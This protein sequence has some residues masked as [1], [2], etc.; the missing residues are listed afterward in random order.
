MT[1]IEF[2]KRLIV[3]EVSNERVKDEL[4]LLYD[5]TFHEAF[6]ILDRDSKGSLEVYDLISALQREFGITRF[7]EKEMGLFLLRYDRYQGRKINMW[8]FADT[9]TPK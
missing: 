4:A 1:L 2:L 8:D 3:L 9:F 7:N 6:K 5:F